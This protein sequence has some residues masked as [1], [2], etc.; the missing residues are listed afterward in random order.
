[1]VGLG[2]VGLPLALS[3]VQAGFFVIGVDRLRA[4]V[5]RLKDGE[6]PIRGYEPGLAELVRSSIDSGRF[7]VT[8]DY[9]LLRSAKV[10]TINVD[11]PVDDDRQPEYQS[12]AAAAKSIGE[13]IG[14]GCL[15]IVE[16]TVSPGTTDRLVA[17]T[18]VE[19][20][21]LTFN[22]DLFVGACPE[23]V[24]PGRLLQNIRT[25][26]RTC[27]GSTPAVADLMRVLYATVVEADLD[28]TDV[29]T[30]E[31]VKVAENAY[32]DVQIAFANEIS[33]LCDELGVDV[34]TIRDLVNKV[35]FRD[36]H[37]PGGGVGGHCLPKDPW[38][39]AAA[40]SHSPLRLIPAARMVNDSMPV[41][42]ANEVGAR[43]K[44]WQSRAGLEEPTSVAVLGYSYLPESDDIR[45]TPSELLVDELQR[46]GF[47]VRIHDPFVTGYDYPL[48]KA[49]AGC[50]AVVVMVPHEA[51]DNVELDAPVVMRVGRRA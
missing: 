33:M 1:V 50:Q 42:V 10:I 17:P 9:E 19:E 47:R 44:E 21:G 11:T 35:P 38:L 3:F 34:W 20:S 27:G 6:S 23:R 15:V 43:I 51:Y 16:S 4:R 28:A 14:P 18:L 29:L 37:R 12:L 2:Y 32:R 41:H 31:L 8:T 49:L 46:Q 7:K 25:V 45:N 13:V 24:M 36:M 5:D 39:L 40:A 22:E 48:V 26:A 30:A